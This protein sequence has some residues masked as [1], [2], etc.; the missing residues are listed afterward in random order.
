MARVV[1][2]VADRAKALA[3]IHSTAS[4]LAFVS[5][6]RSQLGS[7]V[8]RR[9]ILDDVTLSAN[10][11]DDND[12]CPADAIANWETVNDAAPTYPQF[13]RTHA[14]RL[15][16]SQTVYD[17]FDVIGIGYNPD[18]AERLASAESV[19]DADGNLPPLYHARLVL[20]TGHNGIVESVALSTMPGDIFAESASMPS[21]R[22]RSTRSDWQRRNR[23]PSV[24]FSASSL[25]VAIGNVRR[26]NDGFN[27][28][29]DFILTSADSLCDKL[30]SGAILP[31]NEWLALPDRSK[32]MLW[33]ARQLLLAYGVKAYTPGNDS[34]VY[35]CG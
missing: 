35:G 2:S 19:P 14:Q 26:W 22:L 23:L 18:D 25:D 5:A 1:R 34:P 27:A 30:R 20:T 6:K 10:V 11:R 31:P 28:V 32:C 17:W 15:P 4:R 21:R 33:I 9:D 24:Y 8:I 29:A 3:V 13:E 12:T 7:N 16:D